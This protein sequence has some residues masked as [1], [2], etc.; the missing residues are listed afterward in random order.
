MNKPPYRVPSIGEVRS[1]PWNGYRVASLFAGGG[2]SSTGYRMA[3]YRVVW[4]NEFDPPAADTYR[5]N[6]DPATVLDTRSIRDITAVDLLAA[7]G[8]AVGELDVLDGSPPC[9][10]FSISGVLQKGWGDTGGER[11]DDLFWEYARILR[12]V[13]PRVFV[14]ENVAGLVR[15]VS[16]GYF[17]RILPL[18]RGCGYAVA[19]R[20]LDASRLGVP[21]ARQR[22]IFVGVRSDLG[23][24]PAHPAPEAYQYTV[25]DAIGTFPHVMTDPDTGHNLMK[26]AGSYY[27][28]VTSREAARPGKFFN[29][30]RLVLDKPSYTLPG[31][32]ILFHPTSP[33]NL[34]ISEARALSSFPPDYVLTGSYTQRWR[35]LGLSVPPLMMR[36][37]AE[38]IA[39]RILG[40]ECPTPTT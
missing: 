20:V 9:T 28:D 21:Q 38:T 32:P 25:R 34:T 24:A 10:S 2:G 15:G 35:R 6:M 13:Q 23:I 17:K 5:A 39:T 26:R 1:V 4:A 27:E 22:L 11:D 31:V 16:K 12:D 3:G 8:L 19:A 14:A 30:Q 40:A 37:V 33:R 29:V 18:L 36:A 7:A